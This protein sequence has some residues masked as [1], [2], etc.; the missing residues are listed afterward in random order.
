ML[1]LTVMLMLIVMLLLMLTVKLRND[2]GR[3]LQLLPLN[4]EQQT[5]LQHRV[6]KKRM[7]K[8]CK[9]KLLENIS[10]IRQT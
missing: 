4:Q 7:T 5:H 1:M 3:S 8:K 6:R 9:H 10:T 2:S